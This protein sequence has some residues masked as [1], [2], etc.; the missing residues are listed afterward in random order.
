MAVQQQK[1]EAEYLGKYNNIEK[2]I[3]ILSHRF[4]SFNI[5]T[6]HFPDQINFRAQVALQTQSLLLSI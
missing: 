6:V 1:P 4:K 2:Y 5:I 3:S